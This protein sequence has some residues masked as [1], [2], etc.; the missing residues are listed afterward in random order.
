MLTKNFFQKKILL[1]FRRIRERCLACGSK[2]LQK[3]EVI[4]SRTRPNLY[5]FF[6]ECSYC[7]RKTYVDMNHSGDIASFT[8]E[9]IAIIERLFQ[10]K[11]S[12]L[13]ALVKFVHVIRLRIDSFR[14]FRSFT[15]RFKRFTLNVSVAL[16]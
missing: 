8:S 15:L 12:L 2:K 13:H 7:H 16:G 1:K 6:F 9:S 4:T 5:L 10:V 14:I 11:T 3:Y